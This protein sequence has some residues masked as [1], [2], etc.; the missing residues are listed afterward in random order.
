LLDINYK[1][2]QEHNQEI[3]CREADVFRLAWLSD[4]ATIARLPLINIL[5]LNEGV[6]ESFYFM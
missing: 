6:L 3:L 5:G 1:N 4:G 2:I